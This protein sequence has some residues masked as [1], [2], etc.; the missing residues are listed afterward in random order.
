MGSYSLAVVV[1]V[2]V[3]VVVGVV[4]VCVLVAIV[5]VVVVVVAVAV[6]VVA[7]AFCGSGC[8]CCCYC[9]FCERVLGI[10]ACV[11]C[12]CLVGGLR[13]SSAVWCV[14]G[15]ECFRLSRAVTL[16]QS[17]SVVLAC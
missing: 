6:V 17:S 8:Y 3:V 11:H 12:K 7:A 5:V 2:V 1:A 14:G 10:A 15:G 16:S 13:S 9:C 4:V